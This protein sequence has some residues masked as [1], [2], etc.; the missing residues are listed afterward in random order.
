MV[1]FQHYK[2]SLNRKNSH[3]RFPLLFILGKESENSSRFLSDPENVW[4]S[5]SYLTLFW[6]GG[7][8]FAPPAGFLNIA[9]KPL[10]L[11]S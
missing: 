3:R 8:K 6:T 1:L 4:K 9:Q 11:G 10:G 5:D 2:T 7:G